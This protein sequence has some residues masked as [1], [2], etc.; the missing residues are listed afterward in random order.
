MD[1]ATGDEEGRGR[2]AAAELPARE[3]WS[4]RAIKPLLA[5]GRLFA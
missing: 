1:A 2:M 5:L 4:Y 3:R